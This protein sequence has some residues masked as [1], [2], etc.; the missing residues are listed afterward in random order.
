[1]IHAE[2]PKWSTAMDMM[3]ADITRDSD[4]ESCSH[5]VNE[6][7]AGIH[8]NCSNQGANGSPP[9]QG[10]QALRGWQGM[11]HDQ[12]DGSEEECDETP[13]VANTDDQ[14]PA[15]FPEVLPY[16]RGSGIFPKRTL[17]QNVTK[18]AFGGMSGGKC[19]ALI[20]CPPGIRTPIC[21]S[22]G[23]CPTIERGGNA[24][25]ARWPTCL[26]G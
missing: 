7:Q 13:L 21:C 24:V 4:K 25:G 9:R 5:S 11:G 8:L 2:Q 26:H 20:G 3:S 19:F 23:S 18:E 6:R 10:R 22:R 14:H 15:I 16:S 12:K 1:M 17:R